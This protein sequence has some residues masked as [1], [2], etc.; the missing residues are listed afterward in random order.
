MLTW[1]TAAPVTEAAIGGWDQPAS[2]DSSALEG[3]WEN[4]VAPEP[5]A[6]AAAESAKP[7]LKPD[8]TRSWASIFNKPAP[9]PV[10]PKASRV[11][12]TQELSSEPVELPV[13][14]TE[15]IDMPGLPPPLPRIDQVAA[16]PD[17]PPTPS[18]PTSEIAVDIT[19]SK[20][21]LTETNVEQVA[22]SSEPPAT[23]TVASTIGDTLDAQSMAPSTLPP[24]EQ[25]PSSRPPMGGYATTAYK[26]TGMPGRSA[27]YQ[28][29]VQ[30]QQEAVVMPGKHAVDRAAVQFGSMGL[31]GG[32]DEVE[33]EE[34]REDAETRTQPPQHSPIAPRAT[35]PPASQQQPF[36][37]QQ[38][39]GEPLPITRQAPG[40]P[41]VNQQPV[42]PPPSQMPSAEQGAML[43]S[44]QPGYP[45]NQFGNRFGSQPP[46]QEASAPPQK[47]YEPFGGQI[48]Q[49]HHPSDSYS[50]H[51]QPQSQPQ[52]PAQSQV[53]GYS[54]APSDASSL[55]TSDSQRNAYQNYYNSYGQQPQAS[56]TQQDVGTQQRSSSVFGTNAGEQ[57]SQYAPNQGH[58]PPQ[59]RYGPLSEAHNSGH[60]TPNQMLPGQ[61]QL[62]QS[63]QGP[64]V[65]Q[66]QGQGQGAGQHG[67]YPY[68]HPYYSGNP[69]YSAYMN[70][71]SH[72][73]YGR[74]R[75][76]FDD[77]RRYD[78]QYLTH[79]PQ[80]GYGG[81]QGGYGAAPFGGAGGKQGMYGQPHQGYGMS[82][83]GSYDQHASSPAN[84]GA[85]G[86][87]HSG[88]G[89]DAA[90][91]GL[92]I[93]A[94]SGSAQPPSE[95]QQ[96]HATGGGGAFGV[97][98]DFFGRSQAG[99]SGQTPA[100]AHQH[101]SQQGSSEDALRAYG[102]A[103]KG[104]GGPSP[105]LGQPGARPGSAIQGQ[106]GL[107]PSQNQTQQGYGGY[108]GHAYQQMQ[109]QHSSQHGANLAGHPPSGS[110][111][112]QG[113]GYGTGYGAGFGGS[114]YGNNARG[115]WAGSYG[116]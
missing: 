32:L 7:S 26:A 23:D 103:S 75:P 97:G 55:Y 73:S 95:S 39:A 45:F 70:Q 37:M 57:S 12:P 58:P 20:D 93:Y 110:Q 44:S 108:P 65:P 43:Q 90:G 21:E 69:Y 41:P 8:G 28:R 96:Q 64:Q 34:D 29:R 102:D 68:G 87:Q 1:D 101:P 51:S 94:R 24:P 100:F 112:H 10:V 89:R 62:N 107:P 38:S 86:Q 78:D 35:L 15:E 52:M 72:H 13:A 4:V 83:Q 60:S 17:T 59:A 63:H 9:A 49:N 113:S 56:Q 82:P 25:M 67:G 47:T 36:P 31:N 16:I 14:E 88:P 2:T 104:A 30:E 114:Y 11:S 81:N 85:F 71:V 42:Q 76:M 18:L 109:G 98:P 74:E 54:A 115:G 5:A 3:S 46:P 84:L 50:T 19:P 66:P 33:A 92:G 105:A 27:S 48:Q 77:V 116:H 91:G 80:F 22:D 40:L 99:Y 79:N 106:P 61:Q 6:V 53:S 111:Q